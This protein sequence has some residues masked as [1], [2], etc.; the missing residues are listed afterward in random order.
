MNKKEKRRRILRESILTA[1][2][3]LLLLGAS[4]LVFAW[5]HHARPAKGQSAGIVVASP[6]PHAPE[7][8]GV[9]A[10]SPSGAEAS[11]LPTATPAPLDLMASYGDRFSPQ[12][13]KSES[14]YTGAKLH[15]TLSRVQYGTGKD[16]MYYLADIYV[17]DVRCLKTMLAEDTYGRG[18]RESVKSMAQRGGGILA[19][20][21][22][23]Y[24]NQDAGIVIRNGV[25]HREEKSDFDVCVLYYDGVMETYSPQEFSL[26]TAVSRGAWQAWSFGPML[27]DGEG[28]PLPDARLN[29]SK[30]IRRANP[31]VGL[32]YYA[33]GHHCFIVVD[34]R[35]DEA[36]GLTLEAFGQLFADLGCKAA[37]N[38]DGGRSS[39]MVYDGNVL[40]DPYKGGRSVSDC[41]LLCSDPEA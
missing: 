23:T 27:L 5:F 17:G 2:T 12:E 6:A 26:E 37:Y 25:V 7:S 40:N 31:R 3:T 41:I 24:G 38:L 10:P 30:N 11:A 21:G 39:F 32:G 34:G 19:I 4:L 13:Q 33:P 1:L 29:T 18:I 9:P 22:D 14:G 28:N 15:F 8:P 16:A 35:T 36:S 20:T